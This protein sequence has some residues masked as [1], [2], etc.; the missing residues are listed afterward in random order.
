MGNQARCV[1][2]R[3]KSRRILEESGSLC[4]SE[5]KI[6]MDIQKMRVDVYLGAG[7]CQIPAMSGQSGQVR[8]GLGQAER[9][10]QGNIVLPE[11]LF[12]PG[13]KAP[14]SM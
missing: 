6:P 10:F 12:C 9:G 2:R 5:S 8:L 14:I 13:T 3:A 4:I 7:N 1:P 11:A